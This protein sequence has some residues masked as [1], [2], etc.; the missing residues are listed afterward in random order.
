MF[1]KYI[2]I[3]QHDPKDCAAACLAT[4]SRQYGLK[5]SIAKIR[6]YANTDSRGTNAVGII[7]AA[8][9]LGFSAKAVRC[10]KERLFQEIPLP[11]IAHVL[12]D[13]KF[14]H[15]VV[16]HK[17]KR[18]GVIIA[19]P[20]KGIIKCSIDDFSKTWTNVLI[21]LVPS[22]SFERGNQSKGIF[23]M[24]FSQLMSQKKLL[25]Y[26]FL[27]SIL[28]TI[29]GILGSFYF[30]LL[31]DDI[32]PNSLIHTLHIITF[33]VILLNLFKTLLNAFRVQ[34]MLY[35]SQKLD[36]SLILGYYRHVVSLPMNFFNTRKAGEIISRLMDASKVR[37]AVS[38][39]TL[40]IMI[41]TLMVI[42]GGIILYSQNSKLFG[43]A[44]VLALLYAFIVF[45]FNKPIRNVNRVQMENNSQLTSYLFES[46]NGI[47]TIKSL[48]GEQ[49]A[50]HQTEERFIKLLQSLFKGGC[51]NNISNS[52]TNFIASISGIIILWVGGCHIINGTMTIGELLTFNALLLYFLDPI[53][54][55][56]NLQPML[57]TAIVASERLGE[58]FDLELEKS[59]SEHRKLTSKTL[60]GSIEFRNVDFKYGTRQ[61]ILKNINFYISKGEKVAIV[62]ESGSGK[63]TLVK[64]I[65][66]FYQATKGD[67]LINGY[68]IKD[69]NINHL[70][71][72]IA[73][74]SQDTF[75]FS[76]TIREN[77][78]FGNEE[79]SLDEIIDASKIAQAYDF[80]NELPL[81]YETILDEN[82]TNLSGGQKQRLSITRA[83]LRKPDI[84]I[85]D[86]ATSNLD[87]ITEKAIEN[88][89]N[90]HTNGIT[91]II[92]A[93]RLSTIM[94]C[95]KIFVIDNGE[96]IEEGTHKNLI[97]KKGKYY[98]LWKEQLPENGLSS[99]SLKEDFKFEIIN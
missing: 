7:Q 26:V 77:L 91:T 62:G 93:H 80:I 42:G 69:I 84:L 56:I 27:A 4:I 6:E 71:D 47:E 55:L 5:I 16:I 81:R 87:S 58:I 67:I 2:C 14:P 48:N 36:I 28:Y 75:L 25:M 15:F 3:K 74:I 37:E 18:N 49:K 83:L 32:L 98:E 51:I 24:I 86:E 43:I 41:D 9:N 72:R 64:L 33:G 90:E 97:N 82:G 20:D 73:Y 45:C 1:R 54:N 52:F 39:A 13:G 11:A 8:E 94:R 65:M 53:K 85:M 35:L 95:D 59:D 96:F 38:G 17:L 92:I 23:S 78:S 60:N 70:R 22:F 29:L 44:L 68:N 46:I 61:L 89:I 76:G 40:T 79:L 57:Q 21:L 10:K 66:N 50:N 31:M 12:I 88:T 99:L 34:L 19:D 63:T 30:K